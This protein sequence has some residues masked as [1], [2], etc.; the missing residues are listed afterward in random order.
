MVVGLSAAP[1]ALGLALH[2]PVWRRSPAW[3]GATVLF[4]A[5]RRPRE[6]ALR[7]N[8]VMM[9]KHRHAYLEG[10]H[11]AAEVQVVGKREPPAG[12]A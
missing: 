8:V 7:V 10:D 6:V 1:A 12:D 9:D 5:G 3:R 2:L 11:F 4:R